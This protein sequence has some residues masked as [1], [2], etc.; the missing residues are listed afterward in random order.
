MKKLS[1]SKI[2]QHRLM[3][4]TFKIGAFLADIKKTNNN[5]KFVMIN[6]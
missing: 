6:S 4:K 2:I 1:P 5:A 3:S